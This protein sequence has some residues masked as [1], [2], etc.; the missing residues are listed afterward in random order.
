[1][2]KINNI[3]KI[4]GLCLI[5]A[6]LAA[7]PS[8]FQ[9]SAGKD[10]PAGMGMVRLSFASPDGRTVLPDTIDNFVYSAAFTTTNPTASGKTE[11]LNIGGVNEVLLV[12]GMWSIVID[13]KVN[14]TGDVVGR[15]SINNVEIVKGASK[16][17]SDIM[18]QPV[19]SN[20]AAVGALTWS[21]TFPNGLTSATLYYKDDGNPS[22]VEQSINALTTGTRTGETTTG[23]LN[24]APGTYLF[25]AVLQG[26]EGGVTKSAGKAE[27]VHIYPNQPVTL[28]WEFPIA[29]FFPTK[30][31]GFS[32]SVT[33]SNLIQI[34]EVA[35]H[36]THSGVFYAEL[37]GGV[38]K[39]VILGVK[40]DAASIQIDNIAIRTNA[41]TIIVNG[42]TYT[43]SSNSI[44]LSAVLYMITANVGTGGSLKT[45][46][47]SDNDYTSADG[48]LK[49]VVIEN[50]AINL[51]LQ[52]DKGFGVKDPPDVTYN[53]GDV[54]IHR[55]GTSGSWT[56]TMVP[57]DVAVS[58][59]FE[60]LP[61]GVV[62]VYSDGNFLLP[63]LHIRD[64]TVALNHWENTH[65]NINT[66]YQVVEAKNGANTHAMQLVRGTANSADVS[67]SIVSE[68]PVDISGTG[69]IIFRLYHHGL[70]GSALNWI[71]FGDG[72]NRAVWQGNN[73][74]HNFNATMQANSDGNLSGGWGVQ[75]SGWYTIFVPVPKTKANIE[76]TTLFSIRLAL[77]EG[78]QYLIDDIQFIS[79][80]DVNLEKIQIPSSS[81]KLFEVGE[82]ASAVSLISG[83]GRKFL[84]SADL[85][86]YD[87]F[88]STVYTWIADTHP[89]GDGG[90]MQTF[91]NWHLVDDYVFSSTN[92]NV[93]VI[94]NTG[95]ASEVE[96]IAS[97]NF[98][99]S[100]RIGDAVNG[101]TGGPMA[102]TVLAG[103][104]AIVDNF[105]YAT[106]D[107]WLD[108]NEFNRGF[109]GENI[110]GPV[111]D[112]W[113][114]H[115]N[116]TAGAAHE[117]ARG[118]YITL[119]QYPNNAPL[120]IGRKFGY[121]DFF[122]KNGS[123]NL[124]GFSKITFM[125]RKYPNIPN[126]TT[127]KFALTNG[128]SFSQTNE[129]S[130]TFHEVDFSSQVNGAPVVTWV[131]V[132]IELSSFTTCN[133]GAVT[134]WALDINRPAPIIG[135]GGDNRI[136][137]DTIMLE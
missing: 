2:K 125:I 128:G 64:N 21:L 55:V 100:L 80:L 26:T 58:V 93:A 28:K 17:I 52:P 78:V 50:D 96:T 85:S 37:E 71:S 81:T 126:N 42:G 44:S 63:G 61:D 88:G 116:I 39:G 72:N 54:A 137:I 46:V 45:I 23:T 131:Q 111:A 9:V 104:V 110:L 3:I 11:V 12:P 47:N 108:Q 134:G 51:T 67:F 7:C 123:E 57:H 135:G 24:L 59:T 20:S 73:N 129:P 38:Y 118:L 109:W 103:N 106:G 120:R 35:L 49:V 19:T 115:T 84:Y 36:T 16:T 53:G 130:G 15:A 65:N 48:A 117:S 69:G 101:K 114:G 33:H 41:N 102:I 133:L 14:G 27:M 74:D 122:G 124:S 13:A 95:A 98:G 43:I 10:I 5:A 121:T 25:R 82:R 79:S 8:D 60:D 6:L 94:N 66:N 18:I 107:S 92:T 91:S 77:N 112:Q 40:D 136:H 34:E 75:P 70:D 29:A 86:N 105:D 119:D 68:T 4:A 87:N 56:F 83:T 127:Y 99:L 89:V 76:V 30:D 113:G 1:M 90:N 97:G 62:K 32:V 22:A 132:T 31:V